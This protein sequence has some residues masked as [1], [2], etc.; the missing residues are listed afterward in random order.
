M[1]RARTVEA[2]DDRRQVLLSAAL[3]EFFERGFTAARMDDIAKRA[4]VSKGALYLY[5]DSKEAL[6]T[7]LVETFALP[8]VERIEAT[9]R[10]AGSARNAIRAV[11]TLAP[12]LVRESPVPLIAKILIA[13]APAFPEVVTTYRKTV[14]ERV[15]GVFGGILKDAHE[16]GEIEVDDPDLTARL[17]VA[18]IMF[19]AMW[20]VV[21]EHD[22]E[23]KLDVAALFALHEKMLMRAL[24]IEEDAPS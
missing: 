5:F 15:L 2:K 19:S 17:I 21:F 4:G 14:I 3:H 23:A 18:P 11:M 24:N 13:D 7:S 16:A 1:Q 6:F 8:N 9:A 12:V 22:S 20:R 10:A